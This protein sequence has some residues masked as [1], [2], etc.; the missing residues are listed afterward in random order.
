MSIL[1]HLTNPFT[2][3]SIK[4]EFVKYMKK[5]PCTLISTVS[6]CI[7]LTS[8]NLHLSMI[9]YDYFI[10]SSCVWLISL[11]LLLKGNILVP[12]GVHDLFGAVKQEQ[13]LLE[14]NVVSNE[15]CRSGPQCE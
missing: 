8:R 1:L 14:G 2:F 12:S 11:L 4:V 10:A 6:M 13:P 9:N 7:R 15:L 3:V 5:R